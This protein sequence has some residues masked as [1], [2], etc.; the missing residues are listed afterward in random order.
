MKIGRSWI[1]ALGK[2][3]KNKVTPL[4]HVTSSG[5]THCRSNCSFKLIIE[6]YSVRCSSMKVGGE[7]QAWQYGHHVEEITE[8]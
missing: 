1:A 2:A 8:L 7:G 3:L 5:V 6:N 4:A